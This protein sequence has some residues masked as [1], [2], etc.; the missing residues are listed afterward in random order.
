MSKQAFIAFKNALVD[1]LNSN[2]DWQASKAS[3]SADA[4]I[5]SDQSSIITDDRFVQYGLSYTPFIDAGRPTGGMPPVEKIFD[6]LQYK[7]YG[8]SYDDDKE[9]WAIAWGIA[10]TQA[11]KGSFK[12]RGNQTDVFGDVIEKAKPTL[13]TALGEEERV[14]FASEVQE[15]IKR[16][17]EIKR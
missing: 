11:K 9:R 1:A 14:N 13:F 17:N 4:F 16:I 5:K 15:E 7:K 3:G 10:K 12:F 6:W 2:A 8:I